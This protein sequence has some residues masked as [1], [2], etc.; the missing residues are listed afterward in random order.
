[1]N[2]LLDT[3]AFLWFAG[4]EQAANL[5]QATKDLLE[6]G[7]NSVFLSLASI[8]ELAIKVSIGKIKLDEPVKQ[9]VEFHVVHNNIK[10]LSI[11]LDHIDRI[12]AMP[13]H[14]KDPFDR[15]LVAQ[16]TVEDYSLVSTDETL[17]QYTNKRIWLD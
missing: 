12:E 7:N 16:S 6:D 5:P 1:M 10:L 14:H 3:H 13:F 17:D 2:L 4:K 8:W 9:L 15:I 11:K